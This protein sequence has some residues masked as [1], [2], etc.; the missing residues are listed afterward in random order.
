MRISALVF[1]GFCQKHVPYQRQKTV[2]G[3]RPLLYMGRKE[4]SSATQV[5]VFFT[6]VFWSEPDFCSSLSPQDSLLLLHPN[7]GILHHQREHQLGLVTDV[8]YCSWVTT[9]EKTPFWLCCSSIFPSGFATFPNASHEMWRMWAALRRSFIR[10][11]TA[12][13]NAL[14][15]SESDWERAN[16]QIACDQERFASSRKTR[17]LS[18]YHLLPWAFLMRI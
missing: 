12:M 8:Y 11:R 17:V 1:L 2:P 5:A 14:C 7:P 9:Q 16:M 15:C 13:R 10:R 4:R 18:Y 6:L 3:E